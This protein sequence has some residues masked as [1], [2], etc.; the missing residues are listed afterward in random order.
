MVIAASTGAE[1]D[2]LTRTAEGPELFAKFAAGA[3]EKHR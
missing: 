1:D 3:Y 2:T